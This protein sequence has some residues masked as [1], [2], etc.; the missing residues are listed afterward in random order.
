MKILCIN[1]AF[2][3]AHVVFKNNNINEFKEINAK[4]QGSEKV[5]PAIEQVLYKS[6]SQPKDLTHLAVVVGPGSFT[7]IRIGT[8]IAK[9]FVCVKPT[10][11]LIAINSL[12]LMAYEFLKLEQQNLKYLINDFKS[13]F[14]VQNALSKRFFIAEFNFSGDRL[15]KPSLVEKLPENQLFV[16]LDCENFELDDYSK[17]IK[18]IIFKPETLLEIT[19]KYIQNGGYTGLKNFEPIYIRLSQAE[20]NLKNRNKV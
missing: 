19:L 9:G 20:E 14:S 12:D 6:N 10:I 15:G 17:N 5:L 11:K 7:G 4:A 8:A 2:E 1:T 18:N 13:F 16:K 3:K